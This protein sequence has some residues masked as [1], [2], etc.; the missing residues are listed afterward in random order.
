MST[1][2]TVRTR[3]FW[4]CWRSLFWNSGRL[5]SNLQQSSFEWTV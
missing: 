4:T 3:E 1:V 5:F 2:T